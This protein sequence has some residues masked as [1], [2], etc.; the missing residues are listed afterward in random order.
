MDET[1]FGQIEIYNYIFSSEIELVLS[2]K[3]DVN[4][5]KAYVELSPTDCI[6]NKRSYCA[7]VNGIRIPI[8]IGSKFHTSLD[9]NDNPLLINGYFIIDGICKT[10]TS[11]YIING[12]LY[13]HDRAYLSEGR[14]SIIEMG[15]MEIRK[16]K[17]ISRWYLP[18]NYQLIAKLSV[19]P[20]RMLTH[21]DLI[22]ELKLPSK[23]SE[24][25]I[26]DSMRTINPD[27]AMILCYMFENWLGISNTVDIRRRLVTPGEL[28]YDAMSYKQD[29]FKLFRNHMWSVKH[30]INVQGV[31]ED[32]KHCSILNDIESVR[33][34]SYPT[35]R[36]NMRMK[37]RHVKELERGQICPVQTSDGSLCGTIL[38]LCEGATVNSQLPFP[39]SV[40]AN[41]ICKQCVGYE[42]HSRQA[43]FEHTPP[44]LDSGNLT[45][46]ENIKPNFN[47]FDLDDAL[48]LIDLKNKNLETDICK[49]KMLFMNGKYQGKINTSCPKSIC[50]ENVRSV[51]DSVPS[52]YWYEDNRIVVIWNSV[53]IIQSSSVTDVSITANY[54]PYRK[55]N[56]AVRAMFATS[57]LKQ[58]L[59]CD[60]RIKKYSFND[61]KRL[62]NGEQPLVGKHFIHVAGWNL[63][64][65]IMPWYGYNV[66]D[67]FVVSSKVARRFRSEKT[68]KYSTQLENRSEVILDEFVKV[69]DR[70]IIGT[71]LYKV[72]KPSKEVTIE[73]V[74]SSHV[75]IITEVIGT[76]TSYSVTIRSERDLEVGDKLCSRHGQKGIVSKILNDMPYARDN[77]GSKIEIDMIINPH[78]FPS[79][80]TYGQLL[81][82]K[83]NGSSECSIFN[84]SKHIANNIIVGKCY[85]MAL[86]HQVSD[87]IQYRDIDE[88]EFVS[89]QATAGRL[90]HGGLR[91]GNMERDVLL[92]V[93]AH[94]VIEELYSIDKIKIY[95][96]EDGNIHSRVNDTN[97]ELTCVE[98]HQYLPI[99]VGLMRA[100]GY[101]IKYWPEKR[102]YQ[103]EEYDIRQT[104]HIEDIY[105]GIDDPLDVRHYS[106]DKICIPIL[107]V[108]LRSEALNI[109][110][111]RVSTNSRFI[112]KEHQRLLFGKQGA[113][114][115]LCEGHRVNHCVRS[116]IVPAPELPID[117][118][119]L[120]FGV[121]IGTGYGI[122]NR[123]PT[124]SY[125]SMMCVK[126]ARGNTRCI[127]F[128]PRLCEA[129]NADF[130]GDEM[131]VFGISE[132]VFNTARFKLP[133]RDSDI[134]DYI[135]A[136]AFKKPLEE[137]TKM[138]LTANREG[139][140]LM[141]NSKSKGKEF[142][143]KHLFESIGD[144]YVNGQIVGNISSCYS[145]GLNDG[146]WYLQARA[147]RESAASIGVNTPF[148]GGLNSLCN[149][150]FV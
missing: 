113:Y 51:L 54:T 121:E 20:E 50:T 146:E 19:D 6:K 82:M 42:E 32:M 132:Q 65:A 61:T 21:L 24:N 48:T 1:S 100:N 89:K 94:E 30:I 144:V 119:E 103:I 67:A 116:V 71:E 148:T 125:K 123:Q 7:V 98:A 52:I 108:I 75:G 11:Q 85:I 62:L 39:N 22:N 91:V 99:C 25:K 78:A 118:V 57:M 105:F 14:V 147:A 128:N 18:E 72:Y 93:G 140:E 117:V 92:S 76:N 49:C 13:T 56:P 86:R 35:S 33:R 68:N 138:G 43:A 150:A 31:S 46:I 64:I 112:D 88:I 36:E 15:K 53:G 4:N 95:V 142:N 69:G 73:I 135:L 134:Q 3:S 9:P 34:I 102:E 90:R 111:S 58:V 44:M 110:Y 63:N 77:L 133:I 136:T 70:V 109:L 80:M 106:D 45:P 129:F 26:R 59:T 139:I 17:D 84:M 38:Y 41:L 122:L 96:S 81:E 83:E 115:V 66:E 12:S 114:H 5:K 131:S 79:R 29:V 28:I 107:P 55:H 149:R 16:E 23:E 124:L 104:P 87:K 130:D 141:V 127:R 145:E 101:N 137:I 97:L 60:P 74:C 40:V 47:M 10:L 37:D 27:D 126:L 2:L 120:P 8:M 143:I